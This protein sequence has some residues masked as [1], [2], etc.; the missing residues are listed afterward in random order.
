MENAVVRIRPAFARLGISP[1]RGYVHIQQG[2]LPKPV[3]VGLRASALLASEV[4]AII[5]ARAAGKGEAEI[6]R[7]VSELEARRTLAA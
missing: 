1:S 5:A 7:L 2:L 6:K 3:K 4:D